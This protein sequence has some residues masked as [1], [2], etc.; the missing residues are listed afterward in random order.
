[1]D[2]VPLHFKNLFEQLGLPADDQSICRFIGLNRPLAGST[3]LA[4]ATFWTQA[5]ATFLKEQILA[6]ADWSNW[7]DQLNNALR[8]VDTGRSD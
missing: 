2:I 6:D 1:M 7:I 5:Q 3:A 4:D 8:A